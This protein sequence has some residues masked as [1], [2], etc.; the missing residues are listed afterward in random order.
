MQIP[1]QGKKHDDGERA[2]RRWSAN[3]EREG[4]IVVR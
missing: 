2:N 4:R 1:I 3:V